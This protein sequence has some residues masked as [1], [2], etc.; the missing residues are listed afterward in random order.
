MK[1][2]SAS[3]PAIWWEHESTKEAIL[4]INKWLVVVSLFLIL[5]AREIWRSFALLSL[6]IKPRGIKGQYGGLMAN[7]TTN[8][9]SGCWHIS[10]LCLIVGANLIDLLTYF[11]NTRPAYAF[12]SNDR[13]NTL[14]L[15]FILFSVIKNWKRLFL[16]VLNIFTF[17]GSFAVCRPR[18][19]WIITEETLYDRRI[20]WPVLTVYNLSKRG[21][22]QGQ[23][24]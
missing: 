16:H 3:L 1:N 15:F 10:Q 9:G 5:I 17:L 20:L 22:K 13:K 11:K 24:F 18:R 8:F 14:C 7:I 4:G 6:S 21:K 12:T 19:L 23:F 2:R